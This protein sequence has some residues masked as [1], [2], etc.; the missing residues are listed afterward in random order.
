MSEQE[1]KTV[2]VNATPEWLAER[3]VVA[4]WPSNTPMLQWASGEIVGIVYRHPERADVFDVATVRG[5]LVE[6][7]RGAYEAGQETAACADKGGPVRFIARS[8]SL[9]DHGDVGDV[10]ARILEELA[11][12][13]RVAVDRAKEADDMRNEL[14]NA[15]GVAAPAPWAGMVSEVRRLKAVEAIKEQDERFVVGQVYEHIA[16]LLGIAFAPASDAEGEA[17]VRAEIE[18][19]RKAS[20]EPSADALAKAREEGEKAGYI[21]A[22][23]DLDRFIGLRRARLDYASSVAKAARKAAAQADAEERRLAAE[24][25][26]LDEAADA[27]S[28]EEIPF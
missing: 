12:I 19:L 2:A 28:P 3:V 15:L 21:K 24:V 14:A 27:L 16:C 11:R 7:I 22:R 13:R 25:A 8:M 6:Q 9:S 1:S 20:K 5:W 10:E 26:G 23:N 4:V 18:R 17:L